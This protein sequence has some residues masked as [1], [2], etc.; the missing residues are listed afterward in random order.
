MNDH[1]L[2]QVAKNAMRD[3]YAPYSGYQVGAALLC[4]DGRIFMGCN[5]ENASFSLTACAERT[6]LFKA[7]SEGCRR[8]KAIAIVGGKDGHCDDYAFPC[9]ACRQ[10]LAEFC[11]E[12]FRV[13]LATDDG[14][15]RLAT[16]GELLPGSFRLS[17][18]KE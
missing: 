1:S 11:D 2:I 14:S 5:I 12:D 16:L 4:E 6:A 18:E 10:A 15:V 8:F 9:G 7:V 13:I 17:K 3:A